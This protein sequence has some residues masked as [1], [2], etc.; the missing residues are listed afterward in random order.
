MHSCGHLPG[1]HW[2]MMDDFFDCFLLYLL[3]QGLQLNPEPT[4][5][6]TSASQPLAS[7]IFTLYPSSGIIGGVP[8]LSGFLVST[9][10][11]NSGPHA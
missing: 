4:D 2:I 1:G 3:N 5:A 11:P 10:D 7:P 6:N 8:N 9:G